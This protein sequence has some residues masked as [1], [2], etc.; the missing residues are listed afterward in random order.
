MGLVETRRRAA[1]VQ[2]T[3]QNSTLLEAIQPPSETCSP[4]APED[5]TGLQKTK[6]PK[7]KESRGFGHSESAADLQEWVYQAPND[8]PNPNE[9]G[10]LGATRRRMRRNP[11]RCDVTRVGTALHHA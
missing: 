4:E 7:R 8:E 6:R 3:V 5:I 10:S 1:S 2:E 11:S 9:T